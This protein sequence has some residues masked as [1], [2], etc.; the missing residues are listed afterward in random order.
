[1]QAD[2]WPGTAWEQLRSTRWKPPGAAAD[3]DERRRTYIAALQQAEEMF[4]A[5]ATVGPATRPVNLFYGLSQAGRAIAA[6]AT[7]LTGDGWQLIGH[8][9]HTVQQSMPGPLA[10][11]EV[12]SDRPGTKGSFVRLSELLGSPLLT[13]S[14][15]VR[16]SSLWDLLPENTRSPIRHTKNKAR[17]TPLWIHP[18]QHDEPHPLASVPVVEFP[19]WILASPHARDSLNTYLE[20]FP[21]AQDYHSYR[22]ASGEPDADPVFTHRPDGWGQL[23]MNWK[24]PEGRSATPAQRTSYLAAKTRPYCGTW[25]FFPALPETGRSMHPLMA[26]WAVLHTLSMLA[27]YQPAE[28]ASH[29]DVNANRNAVPLERLLKTAINQVPTAITEAI[30]QVTQPAH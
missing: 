5:A 24:V 6:A 26:W 19:P 8:G 23:L 25:Y 9:I 21:E 20:A 4:R 18:N 16:L 27:R 14:P 11:I 12:R 17:R 2:D 10:D 13:A 1:V 30:N 29:I 3:D 28:W 15:P 7:T 22:R